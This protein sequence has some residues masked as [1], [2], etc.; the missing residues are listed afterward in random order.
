M[1]KDPVCGMVVSVD[2]AIKRKIGDRIYYFCSEA[3]A[4]IY[5]RPELE[6]KAMRRR[7]ALAL[8]GVLSIAVI[9]VLVMFGLVAAMMA[10]RIV[11]LS[12][13]DLALFIISTPIVWVSGWSIY[14]GAYRALRERSVNMD[15]LI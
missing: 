15:V 10:F 5:E 14:Y 11:G 6:L 8:A 12:A 13:W 2:G 7:V 3:C 1:P 4:R 9:R